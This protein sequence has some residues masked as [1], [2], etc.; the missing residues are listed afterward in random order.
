MLKW[1][2]LHWNKI[3]GTIYIIYNRLIPQYIVY[4]YSMQSSDKRN[5]VFLSNRRGDGQRRRKEQT[6]RLD[7]GRKRPRLQA[8]RLTA[9]TICSGSGPGELDNGNGG[10]AQQRPCWT[11]AAEAAERTSAANPSALD[12]RRELDTI[13]GNRKR[14]GGLYSASHPARVFSSRI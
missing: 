5:I 12:N 8:A 1:I 7:N 4:M 6:P 2:E 10:E 9:G 3:A 14:C 13:S 11:R